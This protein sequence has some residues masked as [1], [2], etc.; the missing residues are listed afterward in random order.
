MKIAP[1]LIILLFLLPN[2]ATSGSRPSKEMTIQSDQSLPAIGVNPQIYNAVD[3]SEVFTL[4]IF[5]Y[6][7]TSEDRFFSARFNLSFD[8]SLLEVMSIGEGP[9]FGAFPRQ[10]SPP[11]TY[12]YT[13]QNT[14]HF[15]VVTGLLGEGSEPPGYIYPNE[16]GSITRVT[17][18]T[19]TGIPGSTVSC[20][21]DLYDV[22]FS[23]VASLPIQ[24]GLTHDGQY[25]LTLDKRYIDIFAQYPDPFGGQRRMHDADAYAPQADVCVYAY[26]TYNRWPV[27]NKPVEFEIHGPYNPIYNITLYRVAFTNS[28]GIAK[29]TFKIDWPC[30]FPE[31]IAF[32][33]WTVTGSVDLDEIVVTDVLHFEVG[34]LVGITGITTDENEYAHS[35]HMIVTVNYTS[36]SYQPRP[37][38]L[39]VT[40]YD[41]AGYGLGA[42][43]LSMNINCGPS[44]L[45]TTC[46]AIPKWACAGIGTVYADAYTAAPTMGGVAYCPEAS[47]T[48][49]ILT[50]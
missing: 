40:M 5:V 45:K 14:G 9:F 49:T 36:I 20:I 17:F 3:E 29:I 10:P 11:Y 26:V 32:G 37:V 22:A 23:D 18:K 27:Q 13:Y 8:P 43:T 35:R 33:I 25:Y 1:L 39:I 31:T 46:F 2:L 12:F 6:N 50:M 34:W 42:F 47:K 19:K 16:N 24:V 41:D 7:I 4:D 28:S 21:L 38:F 15:K 44:F 30:E 48:F